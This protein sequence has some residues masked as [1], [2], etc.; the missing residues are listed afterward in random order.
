MTYRLSSDGVAA[1]APGVHWIRIT[2]E[3]QP[4]RGVKWQLI[5]RGISGVPA[6]S[7]WTPDADWTH[8]C[9]LPTFSPDDKKD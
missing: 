4:K 7:I 1:V 5:A 9:P 6:Y 2:A 8:F 3:T